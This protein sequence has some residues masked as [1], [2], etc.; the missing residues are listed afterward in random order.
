MITVMA[1]T[2]PRDDFV[3]IF[4]ERSENPERQLYGILL[5]LM[6]WQLIHDIK[7]QSAGS[8]LKPY[9][10]A[11]VHDRSDYGGVMLAAFNQVKDDQSSEGREHF[12][13]I[14]PM[15]WEDCILLQAADLVAI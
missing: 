12:A 10:I 11:L 7:S 3:A 8:R 6:M 14:A 13:T 2:T 15:G 4:P 1:Y 9:K 5:K